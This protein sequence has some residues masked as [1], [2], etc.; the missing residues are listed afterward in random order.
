MVCWAA[1]KIDDD[2]EVDEEGYGKDTLDWYCWWFYRI[3]DRCI[4]KEK[5]SEIC[6]GAQDPMD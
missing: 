2:G 5:R 4:M 3:P 1:F 6:A